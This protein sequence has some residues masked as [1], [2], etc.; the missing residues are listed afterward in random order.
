LTHLKEKKPMNHVRKML[1]A[2]GGIFLAALLVGALAPKATRAIAAALVQVVNTASNPVVTTDSLGTATLLQTSCAGFPEAGQ[3]GNFTSG[4]CF[5]VPPDKR[6]IV[7]NLDGFCFTPTG[8]AITTFGLIVNSGEETL[9]PLPLH[10]EGVSVFNSISYDFNLPVRIY[11]DPG[12][13]FTTFLTTSD[14]SASS[15]CEVNISGRLVPTS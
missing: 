6:A 9:H 14:R 8:A 1:S 15:L 3:A 7:E 13:T 5:T 12:Q 11:A 10:F 4:T 2:L